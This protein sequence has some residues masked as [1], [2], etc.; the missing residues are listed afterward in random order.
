MTLKAKGEDGNDGASSLKDN[1]IQNALMLCFASYKEDKALDYL[2]SK[3][4]HTL[5]SVI[6][7]K[8]SECNFVI[9]EEEN[10]DNVYIAFRGTADWKD[11]ITDLSFFDKYNVEGLLI[12]RYHSG[13]L[14]RAQKFPLLTLLQKKFFQNKTVIFC[15]HS[16]GGAVSSI[17]TLEA[18]SQKKKL[19]ALPD[20]PNIFN[21]TFGS[22]LFLDEKARDF[23][24]D[25]RM[26]EKMFHFLTPEDPVPALLARALSQTV[27]VLTNTEDPVPGSSAL[28]GVLKNIV[29]ARRMFRM[30]AT[31][32]F[33][34]KASY[35]ATIEIMK[36]IFKF[37]DKKMKNTS[38]SPAGEFHFLQDSTKETQIMRSNLKEKIFEKLDFSDFWGPQKLQLKAKS[39]QFLNFCLSMS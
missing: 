36:E 29:S 38:Y 33:W 25:N 28:F 8:H 6:Q 12:G 35:Q 34:P 18:L 39:A 37:F 27:S 11:V 17:V 3:N 5:K 23:I 10:S 19:G 22:P 31:E 7:S 14:S 15:G 21:I 2:K 13:F 9:A 16:L 32:L 1:M 30:F 24:H 4:Q 26:F 20:I